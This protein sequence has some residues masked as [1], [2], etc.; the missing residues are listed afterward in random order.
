MNKNCFLTG[1]VL[2]LIAIILGAFAAHGLKE[3]ISVENQQ[4]FETGVRYQMYHGLFLLLVGN[5]TVLS[6]KTRNQICYVVIV[7]ILLFSGSIYGLATNS[8][9]S[10]DFRVI[11]FVTPIGG[12]FLIVSWAILGYKIFKLKHERST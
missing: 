2:G 5:I 10:F 11:G 7:G 8:L 9:S 3:L 6:Q 12:L 4:T 1:V